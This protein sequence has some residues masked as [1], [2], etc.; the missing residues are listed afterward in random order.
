[1]TKLKIVVIILLFNI[2]GCVVPGSAIAQRSNVCIV[3]SET[4]TLLESYAAREVRRYL[5]LRTGILVPIFSDDLRLVPKDKDLIVIGGSSSKLL[6]EI[7][8]AFP[9][10]C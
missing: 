6:K 7:L 1:M 8:K 9:V 5:Y 10:A 3:I 4:P 2:V